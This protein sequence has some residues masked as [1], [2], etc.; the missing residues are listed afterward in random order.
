M[1]TADTNPD[2]VKAP[3]VTFAEIKRGGYF[4]YKQAVW[5]RTRGRWATP[6]V[7]IGSGQ[8]D[9][10]FD[11]NTEVESVTEDSHD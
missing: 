8:G 4:R 7:L 1:K 9:I 6:V 11:L 3:S 5:K 2:A 10:Y